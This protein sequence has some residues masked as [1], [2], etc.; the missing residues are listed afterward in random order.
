M[1]REGQNLDA[2]STH[3]QWDQQVLQNIN[4]IFGVFTL[5]SFGKAS[6]ATNGFL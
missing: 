6:A 4:I 2:L 3:M 1:L 5:L